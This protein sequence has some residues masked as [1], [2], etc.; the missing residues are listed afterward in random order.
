VECLGKDSI[1]IGSLNIAGYNFEIIEDEGLLR[2]ARV[3]LAIISHQSRSP[4][5][6]AITTGVLARSTMGYVDIEKEMSWTLK[7]TPDDIWPL[8]E[9]EVKQWLIVDTTVFNQAAYRLLTY[10]G[11]SKAYKL[12]LQLPSDL[13]PKY[14]RDSCNFYPWSKENY[15]DCL[16]KTN[17]SANNIAKY[18]KEVSLEPSLSIPNG[19]LQKLE[20]IKEISHEKLSTWM[21][22]TSDDLFLEEVEVTV[23]AFAPNILADIIK[24][25]IRS[26]PKRD[27]Q[28]LSSGT[29]F[30]QNNM[31]IVTEVEKE[32]I[33]QAWEI[34]L[35]ISATDENL[36]HA[37]KILFSCVIYDK[38]AEEQ[39]E[40]LLFRK[41]PY[42]DN[43]NAIINPLPPKTVVEYLQKTEKVDGDD[44]IK[45]LCFIVAN[46]KSVPIEA[47]KYLL[48]LLDSTEN[49]IRAKA[50]QIILSMD[51]HELGKAVIEKGWQW[52]EENNKTAENELGSRILCKYGINLSY[53]EI[54]R[55][56]H[57]IWLGYALKER[58]C[59]SNEVEQYTN[60]LMD[61]WANVLM[62]TRTNNVEERKSSPIITNFWFMDMFID[63]GLKEVVINHFEYAKKW[64]DAVKTEKDNR[65]INWT[66]EFYSSLCEVLL[67]IEPNDGIELYELLKLSDNN[68]MRVTHIGM[69]SLT[70]R[71]F[72]ASDN[73]KVYKLWEKE[74][75]SINS[76][77]ELQIK[78]IIIQK[79]NQSDWLYKLIDKW[80]HSEIM[81]DQARALK[82]LG[83]LDQEDG[84]LQEWINTQPDSWLKFVAKQSVDSLNKNSWAKWWFKDFLTNED[85]IRA[86]GS[87]KVF[88]KC[89]DH[90]FWLWNESMIMDDAIK[91]GRKQ[92]YYE[93]LKDTEKHIK[94]NEKKLKENFLGIKIMKDQ[95][96]PW[97]NK[98]TS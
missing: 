18:M 85:N 68:T 88:L 30:L 66:R 76:D 20:P 72:S 61:T 53:S 40:L 11:S 21:G 86:W 96:W 16:S 84:K 17:F 3:A 69:K 37:E 47:G 54:I 44:T 79:M 50:L 73:E 26:L 65:L 89:V 33:Y 94:E 90:R 25:V 75:N 1:N 34:A 49:N 7:T 95:V 70:R 22:Q 98:Y 12:R 29:R 92:F 81:F 32:A 5:T 13:F 39:I 48:N 59:S 93:N 78:S 4:Y 35:K 64:V 82:L 55:R 38:S 62:D 58:G 45:I 15:Q 24:K 41:A 9:K 52:N 14:E 19:L 8:I 60:Y 23:C 67:D 2:L 87:F 80:L 83:F 31:I 28:A 6:K 71:L 56:V 42:P 91:T 46:P 63:D 43:Y 77:K 57:P 10:Y 27:H 36:C 51:N 97:M 74:L